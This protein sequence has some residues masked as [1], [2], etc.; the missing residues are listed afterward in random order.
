VVPFV[1]GGVPVDPKSQDYDYVAA[2]FKNGIQVPVCGGAVLA[3]G[4]VLTAG[5]CGTIN[6][7]VLM[8]PKI[9]DTSRGRRLA[10]ADGNCYT[11]KHYDPKKRTNDLTLIKLTNP[12]S[13]LATI[14]LPQDTTWETN[15]KTVVSILGWGNGCGN[16][17]QLCQGA[18]DFIGSFPCLKQYR[19]AHQGFPDPAK[20]FCTSSSPV[21][22][23]Q[24]DSGGPVLARVGSSTFLAGI[25]SIGVNSTTSGTSLPDRHMR[26]TE[27]ADWIDGVTK[28][29]L[30]ETRP[31]ENS[32][33]GQP[34]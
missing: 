2:L 19:S 6:E 22:V 29:D 7:V 15:P 12:P 26:L 18:V 3:S 33:E 13:G 20:S 8:R 31:C 32:G 21:G 16:S 17:D 23:E 4:W 1:N 27:Y 9:S 11:H 30:T 5:H 10:V 14:D 28:G 34:P 25:I 24:G